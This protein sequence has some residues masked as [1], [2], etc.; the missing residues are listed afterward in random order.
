MRRT[1][2]IIIPI[3]MI[4]GLIYCGEDRVLPEAPAEYKSKK[5]PIAESADAIAAGEAIYKKKCE[6]CHGNSGDGKGKNA[7]NLENKPI[8]LTKPGYMAGRSDGQLFWF[9]VTGGKKGNEMDGYGPGTS[10]NLSE[11]DIWKSIL[12]LRKNFTK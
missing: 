7:E 8:D 6:K 2:G 4:M 3:M 10:D 1:I 12:Y 9:I 5:N 11:E